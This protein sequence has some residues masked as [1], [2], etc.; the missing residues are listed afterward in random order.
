MLVFVENSLN[1]RQIPEIGETGEEKNLTITALKKKYIVF[2]RSRFIRNPPMTVLNRNT[3]WLIELSNRVINE[4]W[5]KSRTRERI[6][7]I[8]LLDVMIEGA[9]FLKAIEDTKK[10]PG[11]ENVSYFE[12]FCKIN[13]KLFK[14]NITVKKMLDKNRRFAYYYAATNFDAQ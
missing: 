10:T 8:Q 6:L 9:K 14:I 4:W 3:G 13:G 2:A 12:N 1:E 5:G 11:I 7:S